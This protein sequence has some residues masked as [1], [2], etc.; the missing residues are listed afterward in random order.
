VALGLKNLGAVLTETN[1]REEAEP[2]IR[3]AIDEANLGPNASM[4]TTASSSA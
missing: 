2:L 1:R 4:S 3:R